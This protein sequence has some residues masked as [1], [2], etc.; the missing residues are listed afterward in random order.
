M[1]ECDPSALDHDADQDILGV[2]FVEGKYTSLSDAKISVLDFGFIRSDVT[3]D[4]VHVW[5]GSFFRLE[6]HLDRFTASLAALRYEIPYGRDE[7][8]SILTECVRR[9]GFRDA[10]VA[11]VC[12]RGRPPLGS[13]DMRLC[14]NNFIA[15]AMPFIWLASAEK[16][17]FGLSAVISTLTRIPPRSIDP[18]IKNY[19]WL[20]MVRSLWE[21]YDRGADTVFLLDFDGQVTE[22]PGFNVFA[23]IR[24]VL[25]TAEAG[26]LEGVTRRTVLEIAT[27]LGVPFA[28]RG[29][30]AE[31]LCEA[32][33][34]FLTSTGGGI[35]PVTKI[36][37]TILGNGDPGPLTLR[38]KDLYWERHDYGINCTP[39]AY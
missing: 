21:A 37:T 12:T 5:K 2:A 24:G 18:R 35:M 27:E 31:E 4:V 8:R 15:Y 26:V 28:E 10:Y 1:S 25:T 9:S 19:N 30:S 22:G 23:V 17:E 29:F 36:E 11:M 7:I 39:I 32:D 34:V 3:Y 16:R 6:S 13:R 38:I 14:K 20:D 33:E